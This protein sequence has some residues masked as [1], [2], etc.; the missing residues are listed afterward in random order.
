VTR[1]LVKFRV[2]HQNIET[3]WPHFKKK[4]PEAYYFMECTR[5]NNANKIVF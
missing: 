1:D 2:L 4:V 3:G 5:K